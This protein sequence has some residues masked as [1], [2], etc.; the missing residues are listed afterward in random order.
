MV[1]DTSLLCNNDHGNEF[2]LDFMQASDDG[3]HRLV[4]SVS[5][6]LEQLAS[7]NLRQLQVKGSVVTVGRFELK[8]VVNFLEYVFGGCQLNLSVAID[9]TAS[10]GQVTERDSLHNR[11]PAKNQYL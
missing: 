3:N 2:R 1:L 10:N 8:P 6:C 11:D 5:T 9:F 4:G 7:G